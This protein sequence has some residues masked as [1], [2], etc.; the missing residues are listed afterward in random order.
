M[1]IPQITPR[2]K[3]LTLEPPS[4]RLKSHTARVWGDL[5]PLF[6]RRSDG[7]LIVHLSPRPFP[8]ARSPPLPGRREHACARVCACV[9]ACVCAASA[10]LSLTSLV[11]GL[12]TMS[13]APGAV[14]R[15]PSRIW[16]RSR[17]VKMKNEIRRE[18]VGSHIT[19][20]TQAHKLNDNTLLMSSLQR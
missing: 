17:A 9:C 15:R 2:L 3:A 13:P 4:E 18:G 11:G 10:T 5:S 8:P 14:A 1:K 7:G 6:L 19:F 12:K 20:S 16:F